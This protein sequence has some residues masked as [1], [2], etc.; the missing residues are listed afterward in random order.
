MALTTAAVVGAVA[1]AGG[2]VSG[3]RAARKAGKQQEKAAQAG[4]DV[5]QA[6]FEEVR[7]GLQPFAQGTTAEQLFPTED[8]SQQ[9]ADLQ[10]RRDELT[11]QLSAGADTA[12]A[13]GL[14]L[15]AR[16]FLGG[17]QRGVGP[18]FTG[19]AFAGGAPG[20]IDPAIG[21]ELQDVNRQIQELE[22]IQPLTGTQR[23]FGLQQAFSGALGPEAQGQAFQQ[24]QESPGTQFL[25]EQGLRGIEAGAGAR[26][27][28][29]GGER[30][31]ELTRFSQGLALQDFGSQFNRLGAVTGTG[32][33]AA[34][35]LGGVSGTSSAAQAG[36][37]G[38]AAGAGAL[39]TLGA[40]QAQSQGIQQLVGQLPGLVDAF[41]PS[42]TAAVGV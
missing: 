26:G 1:T 27:G 20:G 11:G 18:G 16:Q 9:L 10:A 21:A 3:S 7:R 29:G 15:G 31:R 39:G 19:A 2:A 28:L 25:R 37:L 30:L 42:S 41:K 34:Q 32:L 6:Q 36:L 22:S 12:Q 17:L 4:L 5:T 8:R 33:S 35:A 23:A 24:F 40:Q 13:Q 38:R 14:G